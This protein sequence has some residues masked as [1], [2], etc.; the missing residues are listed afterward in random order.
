MRL[1][2]RNLGQMS[3]KDWQ[4]EINKL[5]HEQAAW[6]K[7]VS[8]IAKLVCA[9]VDTN[10]I[11]NIHKTWAWLDSKDGYENFRAKQ[12]TIWPKAVS[13]RAPKKTD[14]PTDASDGR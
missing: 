2:L 13:V 5:L 6:I 14:A 12:P 8:R 9:V 1:Q 11:R 7:R 3:E 10:D 4:A